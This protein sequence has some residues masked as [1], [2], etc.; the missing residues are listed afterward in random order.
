MLTLAFYRA[1]IFVTNLFFIFIIAAKI[2]TN[3]E[4]IEQVNKFNNLGSGLGL[5]TNVGCVTY[6][7]NIWF[8]QAMKG[9]TN[10]EIS[11]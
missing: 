4:I 11:D 8:L 6:C 2:V 1:I 5:A 10:D 3:N 9:P 7:F